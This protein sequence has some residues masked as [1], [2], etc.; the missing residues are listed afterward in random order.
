MK[1][2]TSQFT[3]IITALIAIA[4]TAFMISCQR[5][6][7]APGPDGAGS[8]SSTGRI[9]SM[10]GVGLGGVTVECSGKTAFTDAS[11][12]FKLSDVPA[13]SAM[14]LNLQK[15]GYVATQK[16]IKVSNLKTSYTEAAIS[17]IGMQTT[18][19]TSAN[20]SVSLQ[21]VKVEIPA[22]GLVKQDGSAYSGNA[23]VELTYFNP[24]NARFNDAFPGEFLGIEQNGGAEVLIESFGYIDITISANG[25]KLQLAGG[26][27]ATITY[28]IPA[29]LAAN[30][31]ASMPLW[32]YDYNIGKWFEYGNA[33][34]SG[35]N[36]VGSVFHFS[37]IN[38]DMKD[39]IRAEI[40]GRVVDGDG[41]VIPHAWVKLT[42]VDFAGGGAG[43][44]GDDGV[45]N[46][47]RVK[48]NAQIKLIAYSGGFYSSPL[49]TTTPSNSIK[50]VGDLVI[51]IDPDL[52]S[53]W[54][55][56]AN[57]PC[58]NPRTVKFFNA[59]NGWVTGDYV[60][61]TN[62]GG[63]T[64]IQRYKMDSSSGN[65][66]G[67]FSCFTDELHA[68][69]FGKK[70]LRTN[71]GGAT[72]EE[73]TIG[74]P[75]A[76][77]FTGAFFLDL[78]NG[79]VVSST[80]LYRTTD[81]GNTWTEISI[82]KQVYAS[83][84]YFLD[85][86]NGWIVSYSGLFRTTDGGNTWNAVTIQTEKTY[87]TVYF[88]N[89]ST[90]WMT[91]GGTRDNCKIFKTV[92]GGNNWTEQVNNAPGTLKDIFFIDE[93]NGW[94]V[95]DVG[96]VIH[97]SDGGANWNIQFTGRNEM[98]NSVYFINSNVG[99]TVGGNYSTGVILYT[100]SGGNP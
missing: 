67:S 99:W 28:P 72:W 29:N 3:Y 95:G 96:T 40:R 80:K 64:W 14:K 98:L 1:S 55:A 70:A 20:S 15:A 42:G 86:M 94:C 30:A 4:A 79:W 58:K 27:N 68:W 13:G 2:K 71:D 35:S 19:N 82:G 43:Y 5:G 10:N 39:S 65:D 81:G 66:A 32:Y 53:G 90:G 97:T 49:F 6:S 59:M 22:G 83:K 12:A 21:G 26:K 61:S 36:F 75:P 17:E 91:T 87:S 63:A 33:V 57:F 23:N 38:L 76:A 45:F 77:Y 34:K 50:D 51:T 48:G 93:S 31:P 84:I 89:S 25:E 69:V 37:T 24:A 8:G 60:Y 16:I 78:N 92:D 44:A 54:T 18:I 56:I 47:V 74:Q 46:F 41:N 7:T 52:Q 62:D 88:I 100:E 73:V 85:A 11:G 9:M